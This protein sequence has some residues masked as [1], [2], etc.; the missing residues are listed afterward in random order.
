MFRVSFSQVSL[1]RSPIVTVQP[2]RI[3]NCSGVI[4]LGV[5]HITTRS[6]MLSM[7]SRVTSV[8]QKYCQNHWS[9]GGE[10]KPISLHLRPAARERDM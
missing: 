8:P 4:G 5:N 6:A 7:T 3:W 1:Y 2:P 9:L 10:S